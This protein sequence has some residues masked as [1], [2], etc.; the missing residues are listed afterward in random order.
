MQII[1]LADKEPAGVSLA[2]ENAVLKPD[3]IAS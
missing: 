1:P 3:K 2:I